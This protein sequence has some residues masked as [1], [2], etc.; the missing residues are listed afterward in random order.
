[1][2]KNG[3]GS[4]PGNALVSRRIAVL[5]SG[6]GS[7]L[8]AIIDAIAAKQLDAELTVV[9][10]NRADAVGLE[11]ARTACVETL[12]LD[13]LDTTKFPTREDYDR[14]L[15]K[16]LT[17]R[18]VG[19]VCLA[20]FMRRLSPV[21]VEAFP[22]AILNIHPSLLPAFPGVNAQYQAWEHG[23]KYTG[24]TVHLVTA[25]LD[26]GPIVLQ[27]PVP[28]GDDDTPDTLASR[29]LEQEHRLYPQAI[30]MLLHKSWRLDGRRVLNGTVTR[31]G[32]GSGSTRRAGS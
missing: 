7:N 4:D 29:I 14:E 11:R 22:N 25:E 6:R 13:H 9:I 2:T 31:G 28:V 16:Q 19:L 3:T 18:N 26:G 24:V 10:S 8:Q 1:M 12:V 32:G 30:Q 20:G 15:A 17:I 5:I 23:V 27:E 21:F